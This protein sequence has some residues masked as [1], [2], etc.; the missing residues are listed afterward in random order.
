[1][2]YGIYVLG[3]FL[4]LCHEAKADIPA[5]NAGPAIARIFAVRLVSDTY[6]LGLSTAL[7]GAA[8]RTNVEPTGDNRPPVS[9]RHF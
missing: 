6:R 2:G 3:V 5:S 4:G 7:F 9:R 8:V 1:M